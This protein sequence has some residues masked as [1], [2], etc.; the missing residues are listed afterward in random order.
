M[1]RKN[2]T[3]PVMAAA[4]Q[5][6]PTIHLLLVTARPQR[7]QDVGYR[8]ISRPL[9]EALRQAELRVQIDIVRPGTYEDFLHHLDVTT[10]Q[11]GSGFYHLVHFD[12]HGGLLT[13]EEFQKGVENNR[14]LYQARYGRDDITPYYGQKAFLFFENAAFPGRD[15]DP[16]ADPVEAQELAERLL[17]HRIPVVI[18]NACQS[19][20]QVGASE[21]SLAHHLLQA[22]VQTAL[23]M[24]YSVTVSAAERL[25]TTLYQQLFAGQPLK[26]AIR[27]ARQALHDQRS[28]QAYFKHQ[29]DL[30]DW[31]LP[32]VYENRDQP[33]PLRDPTPEETQAWYAH[34]AARYPTPNTTYGFYGRDL[35]VLHIEKRLLYHN[36]LLVRGMGGAGKTTLLRHLGHWWQ[37]TRFIERVF[38][39]GYDTKAWS[40]DQIVQ[41]VA[42]DLLG[43]GDYHGTFLPMNVEAQQQLVAD[44]LNS[45]RHLIILDNLES[46]TGHRGAIRHTL[47]RK[48]QGALKAF[49]AL[50]AGGKTLLLLGSRASEDWLADVTFKDNRYELAGL[51]PEAASDL[52]EAILVRHRVAVERQNRD[53]QALLKLLNGYPLPLEVVLA[54]LATQTPAAVLEALKVGNVDL[55][56]G[57]AKTKTESILRCIEYSHSNLSPDAQG[58]LQC[59]APFTGVVCKLFLPQY[60]DQLKQQPVLE[61][62]PFDRWEAILQEAV[63]W[64]LLSPHADVPTFLQLQPIF[65]YFLRTRLQAHEDM[66]EAIRTAFRAHYDGLAG[67][68]DDLLED[69]DQQQRQIGNVI[70]PLEYENLVTALRFALDAQESIWKLYGALSSYLDLTHEEDRG[71][72]LGEAVL[73]RL[74]SYPEAQ[75]TGQ[76]GSELVGVIGDIAKRRLLL[77]QYPAAEQAYQR[78]LTIWLNNHA[79]DADQRKKGSASIYHQLGSVAEEQRQWGQA[80]DYYQKALEIKIAYEDRYSQASTYHQ[81]GS[82]AQAQRQWGQAEDYY[83]KALEICIAYEDRYSQANTYHQ[84]GRVAEEQRQWGQALDYFLKDLAISVEFEDQEG[85]A[86][87]LRSL[88]RLW[89]ESGDENVPVA[90]AAELKIS[91]DEV[92]K[93][94]AGYQESTEPPWQHPRPDTAMLSDWQ[95][96]LSHI[97]SLT[98]A[99]WPWPPLILGAWQTDMSLAMTMLPV[100]ITSSK[101]LSQALTGDACRIVG[102]RHLDVD[103]YP[104]WKLWEAH[105]QCNGQSA[106]FAGFW[107]P[108]EAVVLLTWKSTIV[109]QLNQH[110]PIRLSTEAHYRSYTRF[111]SATIAAEEGRF[112]IIDT[113]EGLPWLPHVSS[114]VPQA[115]E[116]Q[117]QPFQL[118]EL[119]EG[120]GRFQGTCLYGNHLFQITLATQ[121]NGVVEMSE[122]NPLAS[123]LPVLQERFEGPLRWIYAPDAEQGNEEG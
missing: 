82:V 95:A 20:K 49:L 83:Q 62:L 79:F 33:L 71:L 91:A 29:I 96:R 58:L 81:L 94:L 52:A 80:E 65:P 76:L 38:E 46:I 3:P 103:F 110:V 37:T 7:E 99:P 50:L 12:L 27:A 17:A 119:T 118:L 13:Y 67:V 86:T 78:A 9:V 32:V 22:G 69:K 10:Q 100:G 84:L 41:S 109:H 1:V 104:G 77:K 39:F 51:D 8:T 48:K 35:D 70:A 105:L 24:G 75:L 55:D 112:C 87:P 15:D 64:G 5:A 26:A 66:D 47:S 92:V 90:V 56:K 114:D 68:I 93:L 31:L 21:T 102:F 107:G 4:S 63:N 43:P 115:L 98:P 36:V 53:F 106:L 72:T 101:V 23:A 74:E 40:C 25:M 42:K 120:V 108:E 59:F 116:I 45:C 121:P 117:V 89:R 60:M 11:H 111:F 19:A 88:T 113:D 2:L 28:R 123:D 16:Q 97:V 61:K 34:Q 6:A 14:Y 122:D 54:N 57:D 44:R 30:H 85:S 18:L 73:K